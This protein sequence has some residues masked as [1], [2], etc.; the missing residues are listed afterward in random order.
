MATTYESGLFGAVVSLGGLIDKSGRGRVMVNGTHVPTN[1]VPVEI[2]NANSRRVSAIIQNID[3]GGEDC[4]LSFGETPTAPNGITL[5]QYGSL[6]IDMNFPWTGS[7]V[8]LAQT[9][10]ATI[11]VS[12]VSL[13]G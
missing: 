2:L 4:Y 6:Q 9:A 3:P 8:A 7:V 12:E 1:T 13:N 5:R 11:W 10:H